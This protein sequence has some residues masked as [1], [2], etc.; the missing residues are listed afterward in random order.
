M[1]IVSCASSY[2]EEIKIVFSGQAYAMLYPCSCPMAPNGGVARRAT[3]IKKLRATGAVAGVTSS[4]VLV[5]EAGSSMASGRQDQYSQNYESDKRRTEAYLQSLTSMGYDALLV[6]GQESVFGAE[7]LKSY[8]DMPF[9]SSNTEGVA[10]P[11]II[12][13]VGSVKV[14]IL[15]LTDISVVSRGLAEW[16]APISVLEQLVSELKKQGVSIIVLLSS[17]QPAEDQ[18]LLRNV[19]G[20]DVVINGA[21]SYG[22]VNLTE[23]E[24]AIYLST[25]WQAKSI[26]VL[27]L[28]T[29]G[30][31][32]IKRDLENVAM[33]KDIPSD[34]PV[35]SLLPEC[36][37]D[38]D[39]VKNTGFISKCEDGSTKRSRCV[40]LNPKEVSLTVVRPRSCRSCHAEE[41]INSLKGSLGLLKVEEISEDDAKAKDIIAEF[42]LTML[43]AYVFGRDIEKSP[44]F[45]VLAGALQKGKASY[46]LK[47]SN[48]GV[49]YI[50]AGKRVPKRLDVFFSFNNSGLFDLFSL[51]KAFGEKHKDH[52]IYLNFIAVRDENGEL[53]SKGGVSEIE[54]FSRLACIDELFPKKTYDYLLCRS[55]QAQSSWWDACAAS[56]KIDAAR[57]KECVFSDAGRKALLKRIKL[58]EELEVASGP[59]IIVDNKEILGIRNVPKLEGFEKAVIGEEKQRGQ[60]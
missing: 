21:Q 38:G 18:E 48:S 46:L 33:G 27:T 45:S 59:T 3:L 19:K 53:M 13:S 32:I 1:A 55:T 29:S 41:V 30:K 8:K 15:G 34:E 47:P 7:F 51:L 10:R 35:A 43:P 2:A 52:S 31:K 9:V 23:V 37:A 56:E 6:S 16:K 22:S 44:N 40:Y 49:S 24:G 54:E 5:V 42:K 39:C 50:I 25:W 20:I 12:K 26:G 58:T 4:N 36:F 17:L 28:E 14:G 57:I 60:L 11:Y